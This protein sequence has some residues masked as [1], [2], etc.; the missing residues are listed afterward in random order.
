MRPK[1]AG[2]LIAV[3][4]LLLSALPPASALSFHSTLDPI[5]IFP[6]PGEVVNHTFQL[7]LAQG[8]QTCHF[9]ARVEDWWLSKDGRE[10]FYREPGSPGAPKHSCASWVKLSPVEAQVQPGE[11][12]AV[13]VTV[14][15][16][17]QVQPGGYWCALTLDELPDPLTAPP[18][19]G[20][21]LYTS[22]SVGIFVYIG[23]VE[24]KA[25]ITEV[26]VL[27]D[28]A[29]LTVRNEGN[30]PLGIEG[31]L[32]FLQ[33]GA[34]KPTDVVVIPRSPVLPEP[35]NSTTLSVPLRDTQILPSG[36]YLV[37]AILDIGADY[38]LGVQKEML[39]SREAK[40]LGPAP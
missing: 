33:P 32:E 6:K 3:V 5:K 9:R 30:C 22:I 15:V 13:K 19:V 35:F 11:T 38:Y 36:R 2:E 29:E 20:M 31:R 23:P 16:P 26:R 24:R 21:R 4:A 1:T 28:H 8:E 12:L 17:Q 39:V 25:R 40:P 18:G 7:T 14:S 10:S 37:R 27:S 34:E